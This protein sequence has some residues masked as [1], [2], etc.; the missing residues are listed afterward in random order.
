MYPFD[1]DAF[2]AQPLTARAATNG[3]TVRPLW[4]LW[5]EGYFWLLSGPWTKLLGRMRR[6]PKLAI[7][8]DVCDITTGM[9]KQVIAHG[10]VEI[11]P[12]DVPR[13]QRML[14]RYLGDDVESWDPNFQ[15]YLLD[16]QRDTVWLRLQPI[17]MSARDLSYSTSG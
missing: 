7:V 8:V 10:K 2:L 3:P 1:V 6:D 13:G 17:S 4:F 16:A 14:S 11:L 12:F 15:S 9:T 5:E